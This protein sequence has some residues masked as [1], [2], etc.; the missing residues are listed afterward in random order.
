M[1]DDE[2]LFVYRA[3]PSSGFLAPENILYQWLLTASSFG[4]FVKLYPQ[5]LP[6]PRCDKR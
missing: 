5:R 4:Q 1:G 3:R 2:L 6:E